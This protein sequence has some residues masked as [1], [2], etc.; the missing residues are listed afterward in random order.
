MSSIKRLLSFG[1]VPV[2]QSSQQSS[3]SNKR[4]RL[5]LEG[6][7]SAESSQA[8]LPSDHEPQSLPPEP[9][10]SPLAPACPEASQVAVFVRNDPG[11]YT[12]QNLVSLTD[13]DRLWLLRNAFRPDDGSYTYPHREKYSKKRTFQNA[14]LRQFP[15]LC[16]SK[17]RNGGFCVY[18][19]LFA[20]NQSLL[21]QL[22]TSPIQILHAQ[23][24]PLMS[25]AINPV[26][27]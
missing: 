1:F 16:Y 2:S 10:Q 15:W 3:T 8:D 25:T 17:S 6:S 4:P 12:S 19:F 11:T 9:Q 22:I 21:G 18:C 23:R 5:S 13:E 14:W 27:R 7:D 24:Q 26:I 20:M